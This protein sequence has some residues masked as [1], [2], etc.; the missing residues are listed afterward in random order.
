[1]NN[2]TTIL[3]I[4]GA[5]LLGLLLF[6]GGTEPVDETDTTTT[7]VSTETTIAGGGSSG[8]YTTVQQASR[9]TADAGES[10]VVAEREPIQL[11]GVGADPNDGPVSYRWVAQGGLGSFSNPTIANPVY[12][13][14]SAC[15]CEDVVVLTF[16]VTNH[17]GLQTSDQMTVVV[18]NQDV[19][20][21]PVQ[22][23]CSSVVCCP[24][25][26]CVEIEDPCPSADVVCDTPCITHAPTDGACAVVPVPCAC[27]TSDC[28]WAWESGFLAGAADVTATAGGGVHA[29]P[30]IDRQFDGR[31]NEEGILPLSAEIR[32]PS[33][34][35]VC[36]VWSASKGWFE[37]ADTLTPI[38]H[39]PAS[40]AQGLERATI[41]LTTYDGLGGRSY[42][43]VRIEIL[44]RN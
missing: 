24:T 9:P 42:D 25:D 34:V 14:P 22:P 43:Q 2:A 35:S 16:T 17:L 11:N 38:Y 5:V 21:C 44:N 4:G 28:D 32:N 19:L 6:F 20:A 7:T 1:V 33:C 39:A 8:Y 31:I 10:L 18:Q 30:M 13:A 26:P 23:E 29:K 40:D 15:D 41:T 3:L 37:D 27:A 36:F 12:T